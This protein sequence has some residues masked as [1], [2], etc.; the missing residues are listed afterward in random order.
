MICEGAMAPKLQHGWLFD[1]LVRVAW[2]F[3]FVTG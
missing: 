2:M 1:R 3:D